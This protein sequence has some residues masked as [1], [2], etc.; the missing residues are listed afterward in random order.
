VLAGGASRRLAGALKGLELL[1]DRRVIDRVAAALQAVTPQLLLVANHP[2]ASH[3]LP[4]VAVAADLHPGAGGLAGVETALSRGGDA[5]V[6][7]WDMPFVTPTL[8]N[9][10]L[11]AARAH[12]AD[13]AAPESESPY[14]LEPFCAFYSARI[15]PSLS[16]FLS[17]GGGAAGDFLRDVPRLYRMPLAEV[18]R[19]GDP[20]QF[21]F[22]VN[23]PADLERARVMATARAS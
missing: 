3:W 15:L 20:R 8:L 21:F 7:A 16:M 18:E 4:G 12:D 5:L 23:T 6:V 2:G 22:S 10:L 9:A 1:G 17:G 13:V 11:S 14:G 19:L